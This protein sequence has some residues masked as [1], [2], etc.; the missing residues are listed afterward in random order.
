AA[1]KKRRAVADKPDELYNLKTDPSETRNVRAEHAELA[2]KMKKLLNEA[3][4]RGFTRPGA[5]G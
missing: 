5:G 3:R 2:A 1:E 4:E